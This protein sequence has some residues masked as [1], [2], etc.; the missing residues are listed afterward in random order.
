MSAPMPHIPG[1]VVTAPEDL[2]RPDLLVAYERHDRVGAH[3]ALHLME[4]EAVIACE[5][6]AD[7]LVVRRGDI[8]DH[9]ATLQLE[10]Y[11]RPHGA[12]VAHVVVEF[13]ARRWGAGSG[14]V[15]V[16]R[17]LNKDRADARYERTKEALSAR[18]E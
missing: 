15:R 7:R 17:L 18:P 14:P 16:A 2:D 12:I 10:E 3:S 8:L 6:P 9:G 1:V 5:V 4:R 11:D 13:D